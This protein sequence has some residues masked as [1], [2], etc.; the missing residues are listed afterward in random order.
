MKDQIPRKNTQYSANKS[1][2]LRNGAR[3]DHGYNDGL[4]GSRIRAFDWYQNHRPWMILNG[5]YALCGSKDAS[6]RAH[7]K[8]MNKDRPI[9]HRG[10]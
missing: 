8:N 5:Q 3:E 10:P 6:F 7:Y 4:I 2:Y 9:L 1:P